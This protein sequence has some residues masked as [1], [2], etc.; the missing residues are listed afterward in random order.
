ML[1]LA[2]ARPRNLESIRTRD[3]IPEELRQNSSTLQSLLESY[4]DF[5]NT[6]GLPSYEL[7]SI[8]NLNDIDKVSRVYFQHIHGLIGNSIPLS[9]ALDQVELYKIIIKYYNSRGSE[10]SIHSFFRIFFGAVIS[11]F[12]PK[13]F[14]FDLSNSPEHS[15]LSDK[16]RVCDGE[17][18]QNYSYVI[19]TDLD[20][21]E[22]KDQYI[23]L[24]HPIGL[25]LFAALSLLAAA[26]NIWDNEIDFDSE[27]WLNNLIPPSIINP[28]SIGYHS[29]RFQ[30]GFKQNVY[31][32]IIFIQHFN[33]D[34]DLLRIVYLTQNTYSG[35]VATRYPYVI[36][37]YL[38]T[39]EKFLDSSAIGE[40]FLDTQIQNILLGSERY[41]FNLS[42]FINIIE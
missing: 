8:H 31:L 15:Y 19:R 27:N 37:Q 26:E 40:G 2:D 14:L 6:E 34:E 16:S 22:W 23:K 7:N 32:F 1:A 38:N 24:V 3:F 10:D 13:D 29:P 12:Y 5:L 35:M 4:Y 20:S 17:Y 21:V 25:K 39:S 11:I 36:N 9:R 18:W 41:N 33:L 30:P 42:A 28:F